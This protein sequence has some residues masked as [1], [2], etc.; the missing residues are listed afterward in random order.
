MD[1]PDAVLYTIAFGAYLASFVAYILY[2]GLKRETLGLLAT[3]L[4]GVGLAPHSAGFAVRWI[5]QGHVPLASM[6]E[7][8]GVMA[9][10]V[11]AVLLV[12]VHR[13]RNR[14]IGVF[15]VP[16]ALMLMVTA[17]LL[18]S[19]VNRQLMPA[20]Q[21]TW[22]AIHVSLAAL[23][24]GAFLIAFAASSLYLL[25]TGVGD[26]PAERSVWRDEV[27][28]FIAAW[29]AGPAA[30]AGLLN[31][32]GLLPVQVSSV[33]AARFMGLDARPFTAFAVGAP[34]SP[35]LLGRWA[36]G[37]GIGMVVAAVFWPVVHRSC[38]P[39]S[40]RSHAGVRM[41]VV[42]VFSLLVSA[43]I[44]GFLIRSSLIR[45]TARSYFKIFEFFGPTLVI[46]WFVFPA[47]WR[48]LMRERGGWVARL[49]MA[50]PALEEV[51]YAGVAIG[52]PLYTIGALFAGAIWAEQAWGSWW[53][54]DPKEVGALVIWL[55]Y[56]GYLHARYHR[57]WKEN[58]A[59]VLIVFGMVMIFISFFGNYFF[60][61][62]HSFEVG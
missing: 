48:L 5:S 20:L 59:A 11:V 38:V 34:S 10:M 61:G 52:Y 1:R 17:S 45:V 41:F 13:Y 30:V 35:M 26:E 23:G 51:A 2:I 37:L 15:L 31:A 3:V 28:L 9:W 57:Q 39:E 29:I 16:I 8:M 25:S 44:T 58:R 43:V 49:G 4:A 32:A 55:F 40:P 36:I 24:S 50:R 53:S 12:F 46:S 60:G 42:V 19:D 14:K 7:Y 62:L 54:W 21:S 18:P 33:A 6:Y 56:T 22:L 27:R 47:L